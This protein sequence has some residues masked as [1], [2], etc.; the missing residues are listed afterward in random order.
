MYA[1]ANVNANAHENAANAHADVLLGQKPAQSTKHP[2]E[3]SHYADDDDGPQQ[4]QR[5]FREFAPLLVVVAVATLRP[6]RSH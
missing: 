4:Q 3:Y 2:N 5:R 6:V 1:Q